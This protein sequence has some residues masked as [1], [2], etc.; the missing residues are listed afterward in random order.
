MSDEEQNGTGKKSGEGLSRRQFLSYALGGTGAFMGAAMTLP[1]LGFTVDPLRR[2]AAGA[3]VDSTHKISD[4]NADLP[5]LIDFKVHQ[6]DAWNSKDVAA[7]AWVIK[8]SKENKGILAMSPI[9]THLGCTVNGSVN[10]SG[11]PIPS[12]DGQWW[13]HC[14]CHGSKFTKY[15]INDPVSPAQRPLDVYDV[16]VKGN[17]L[18]LGPIRQR[19]K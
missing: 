1:M 11:K 17:E 19:T 9:C 10:S 6:D 16:D 14:P 5:L 7:R 2:N 13:F 4:F 8:S 18:W 3:F 15:G 12:T